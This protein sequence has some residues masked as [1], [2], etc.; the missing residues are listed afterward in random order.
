MRRFLLL[1]A[2]SLAACSGNQGEVGPAGPAGPAG[3]VGPPGVQGP[4]GP[5]GLTGP[6]GDPGPQGEVGATGSEG[7]QG[8]QGVQGPRGYTGAQGATGPQGPPGTAQYTHV[9]WTSTADSTTN[10][11]SGCVYCPSGLH[12]LGGGPHLVDAG[13]GTLQ[14]SYYYRSINITDDFPNGTAQ[15]CAKA[16]YTGDP[17]IAPVWALRVEALCANI[18]LN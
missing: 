10:F 5:A 18:S 6:Q 14:G 17:N 13:G 15:W 1:A 16:Y 9:T 2:L 7:P 11:K 8:P 4:E 12:V 3:P